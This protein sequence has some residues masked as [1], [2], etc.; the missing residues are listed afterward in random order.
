MT[1][2]AFITG[3]SG[4]TLTAD[5]RAFLREAEPWGLILFRRNIR[6]PAQVTKLV[7]DCREVGRHAT[8][9]C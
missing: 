7:A 5:E 8:R 3:V 1:A 2:R 4:F 9:R 6:T